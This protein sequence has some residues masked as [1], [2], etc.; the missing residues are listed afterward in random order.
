MS[1]RC[2]REE[3]E[4]AQQVSVDS[5]LWEMSMGIVSDISVSIHIE[6]SIFLTTLHYINDKYGA[7]V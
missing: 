4:K 1:T 5:I 3:C 2:R 7:W 6:K